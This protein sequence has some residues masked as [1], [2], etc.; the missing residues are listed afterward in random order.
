MLR[1]VVTAVSPRRTWVLFLAWL[2]LHTAPAFADEPAS[3][4]RADRARTSGPAIAIGGST[5]AV[6][7][8]GQL[9]F[10]ASYLWPLVDREGA[11]AVAGAY[12]EPPRSSYA[13]MQAD[14]WHADQRFND[15]RDD[16]VPELELT[17]VGTI[18]LGRFMF[19]VFSELDEPTIELPDDLPWGD[20]FV[21]DTL[22]VFVN[23]DGH[24]LPSGGASCAGAGRLRRSIEQLG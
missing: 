1:A 18:H 8:G 4:K 12:A 5:Q 20:E 17:L 6:V 7:L 24:V 2:L 13:V 22:S 14:P 21:A 3:P 11:A 19:E 10:G 23:D 9:L 16:A 15:L